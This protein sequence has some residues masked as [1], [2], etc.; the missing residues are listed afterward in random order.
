M[1]ALLCDKVGYEEY[2]KN[3]FQVGTFHYPELFGSNIC[4]E[5]ER[6]REH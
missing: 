5:I 3:A 6:A 1:T 2:R 4:N